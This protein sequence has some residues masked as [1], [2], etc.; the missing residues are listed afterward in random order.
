MRIFAAA[1]SPTRP[2]DPASHLGLIAF[3]V[4][5]VFPVAFGLVYAVLYGFGLT[6]LLGEGLT[7]APLQALLASG[8]LAES[9]LYSLYVAIASTALT[10]IFG[11]LISRGLARSVDHGIL[12]WGLY[13]PLVVPGAVGAFVIYQLLGDSGLVSRLALHAGMIDN[14]SA[15]P[16]LVQDTYAV[17]I[18]TTHVML[19]TPF[20]AL[21]FDR[22]AQAERLDDM[23]RLA[24]SLGA[25][26]GQVRLGVEAR[27][28]WLRARSNIVLF[29][30]FV[31]GS[32]EIPLLLGTQDPQMTA[33]L[34]WR[35]FA[36]FDLGDKPQAFIIALVF[37][38]IVTIALALGLRR[39]RR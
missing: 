6:G 22:I 32:F 37:G 24:D 10:L 28:L 2:A 3:L 12:A 19:G 38:G 30:L 13:L 11:F 17:A 31:M 20:F 9:L 39:R 36:R 27:V 29:L 5:C 4:L 34:A 14:A 35:K 33:V 1:S 25:R 16:A 18:I 23:V 26:R 15:F 21:F 8:E 7:L